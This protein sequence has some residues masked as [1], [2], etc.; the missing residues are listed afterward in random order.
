M[1]TLGTCRDGRRLLYNEYLYE[2]LLESQP[3][4]L[5]E[6]RELDR[7]A[8]IHWT[9]LEQRDW[10]RRLKP[11]DFYL[12]S[13]RAHEMYGVEAGG[14]LDAQI[15][16]H[17][18]RDNSYLYGKIVEDHGLTTQAAD[19]QKSILFESDWD[20]DSQL[21]QKPEKVKSDGSVAQEQKPGVS[22]KRRAGKL[23]G[24]LPSIGKA[25]ASIVPKLGKLKK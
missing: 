17:A 19:P 1:I 12:A 25:A 14:S 23:Q 16:A 15:K 8:I 4:T 3:L 9:L 20:Y 5:E 7:R 2:F 6:V 10:M 11:N 24:A 13:M 18:R 22:E 21:E